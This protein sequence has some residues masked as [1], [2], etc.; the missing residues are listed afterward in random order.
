M[1][2]GDDMI[3]RVRLPNGDIHALPHARAVSAVVHDGNDTKAP[4]A[5]LL[6]MQVSHLV[7]RSVLASQNFN[8]MMAKCVLS[9]LRKAENHSFLSEL[10]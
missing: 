6:L 9:H 10:I 5:T 7:G 4:Q 8:L 3:F 2:P 1:D